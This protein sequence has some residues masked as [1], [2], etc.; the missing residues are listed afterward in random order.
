MKVTS[1]WFKESEFKRCTPR[2]SLQDMNQYTMHK[3]DEARDLA[4][5][6]FVL[7]SAKRT[8]AWD[9]AR[10]RSGT[11]P[12]TIGEA[13]DIRCHTDSNRFKIIQALIRVGFTRIGVYKTFIHADTS[14]K[15]KQEI[16]WYD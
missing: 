10:G 6:P 1:K 4:G 2:C 13:V 14:E 7:N 3:L 5:I 11:G 16:I 12:H 15:H 9:R 8:P